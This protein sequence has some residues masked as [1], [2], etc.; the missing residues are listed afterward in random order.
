MPEASGV[1]LG[2]AHGTITI[3][4]QIEA[5]QAKLQAFAQQ[6]T[7]Q[8]NQ[9]GAATKQA[10][11]GFASAAGSLNQLTAAF[12]IS[13]SVAG[14]VQLGKMAVASTEL[15]TAYNRQ[16]VAAEG[17]AGSQAKLNELMAIYDR[18]T[19]GILDKS[20]ELANVTQLL[21]VGFADSTKELDQFATAIRGISVATGRSS[22]IIT[23]NLI[24]EL[25]SQRGMRL[26]QLGLSYDKVRAKA[27]QLAQADSSLTKQQAY[28]NAVLDEATAKYGALTHSIEAQK[29]GVE[30]LHKT[31]TNAGLA[32]GEAFGP[33][34]N[35][36]ASAMSNWLKQTGQDIQGVLSYLDPLI[37][38]LKEAGALAQGLVHG[39]IIDLSSLEGGPGVSGNRTPIGTMTGP[40][41]M[42]A[43][44]I[45]DLN[46][47][48]IEWFQKTQD[49]DRQAYQQRTQ[50]QEQ[51]N[52]QVAASERQYQT[53]VIREAQDFGIQ[54]Q[55]A[56]RDLA[57]QLA[58]LH[59]DTARQ[60]AEAARQLADTIA[61]ARADSSD[62]LEQLQENHDRELAQKR[63][64]ASEKLADL[65]ATRDDDIAQKRADSS[66]RIADL[67][68][69][70]NDQREKSARDHQDRIVDAAIGN[71]A[72]S[73]FLE[74]RR[75]ERQ[76][77]DAQAAFDKQLGKEQNSLQDSLDQIDKNY[78]KRVD[79]E[80]KSLDKAID[81]ANSAYERQVSDEK[82]ALDKRISQAQTAYDKQVADLKA[83]DEQ[84]TKDLQD[85]F[86]LRQNDEDADR[87]LRLSRMADDHTAQLTELDNEQQKRLTQIDNQQ[88]EQRIEL[89]NKFR[90][91]L[92]DMGI[93]TD[94]M[95]T[96]FNTLRDD[97][98]KAFDEF[99]KHL[100]GTIPNTQVPT[101]TPP[102]G[103]TK[104]EAQSHI[105]TIQSQMRALDPANPL[106][107][108]L[109]EKLTYWQGIYNSAPAA[110]AAM[111]GGSSGKA[112]A[113]PGMA[114]VS[115]VG[116]F[117][118]QSIGMG[119]IN[120]H[121]YGAPGQSEQKLAEL[122]RQEILGVV[123]MA[124]GKR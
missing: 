115:G 53:S 43:A 7:Q 25:F 84:R 51:F 28:Q 63:A 52:S 13:L 20:T 14:A 64:D 98:V 117:S 106:W 116:S 118:S 35:F 102:T 17:L 55:R 15:A 96:H 30:D 99:W 86:T 59:A 91:Q 4:A 21:S 78:Q 68:E 54:R 41:T 38:G 123:K 33:A 85:A 5:A 27:D 47:A 77:S 124:G 70:Y 16:K 80:K 83:S 12:G 18:D 36:V 37:Q 94:A 107:G 32:F 56:E 121:I 57:Q 49:I 44:P 65:R 9:V 112:W 93:Y 104:A 50:A 6:T 26:D 24:L 19:G 34:I 97:A 61:Q 109:L 110:V 88:A 81:Q 75:Y 66:K 69:N 119:G 100:T 29:T 67:E 82:K 92:F 122:V 3:D 8:M 72:K 101:P 11:Q 90:D 111:L 10:S 39:R 45:T 62:R 22:D 87:A 42:E 89:D 60:E 31:I 46:K 48:Q 1:G 71:D 76:T 105:N 108:S 120:I 114:Q 103:P 23:Q 74:N 95:K 58:Q 40:R 73:L 113:M 2:N 79:T